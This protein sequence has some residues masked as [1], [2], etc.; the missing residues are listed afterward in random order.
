MFDLTEAAKA[1]ALFSE[2]NTRAEHIRDQISRYLHDHVIYYTRDGWYANRIGIACEEF[3]QLGDIE[4]IDGCTHEDDSCLCMMIIETYEHGTRWTE[5][6]ISLPLSL[7][8][9]TDQQIEEYAQRTYAPQIAAK[10]RH[11]ADQ[12]REQERAEREQL[13][14]LKNRYER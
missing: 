12:Q 9:A 8:N 11:V 3:K 1:T 2:L 13:E 14:Q 10:Q 5:S 4:T 6:E 7:L